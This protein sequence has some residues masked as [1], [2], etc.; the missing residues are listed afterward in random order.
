MLI[1]VVLATVAYIPVLQLPFIDDDYGEIPMAAS[2]YSTGW[3]PLWQDANLRAR[4]TN[5]VLN[6]ALDRVFGFTPLPFYV[7][8]IVVHT[9]CVLLVYA[10]GVWSGVLN[11]RATFWAACFFAIFEGHQEA[12]MWISARN[13]SLLFLFGMA[14]WVCWVKYLRGGRALWYGLAV[15]SLIL[16]AV[17]KESFV[18][19][20]VLML[21][22]CIWPPPG[23]SRRRALAAVIPFFAIVA[24]YLSWS[25]VGRTAQPRFGD[26]RFSILAPWPL[27]ILKSWWRMMWMWGVA[28]LAIV[29]WIGGPGDRRKA[30]IAVVWMLLA[31]FPYSF[32]TYMPQIASRHTY[33]ASAGL[34]LLIGVAAARLWETNRRIVLGV[35]AAAVLVINVEIIWVK[36]M[37]Q[38]RERAEPA[39]L[40][41]E[42]AREAVGPIAIH[43]IPFENVLTDDVLATGGSRAV[44]P[45]PVRYEDHC[46]EIEYQNAAGAR[47]RID[48]RVR[49]GKH[50]A[51][52]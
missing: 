41:G 3:A 13:E 35:A 17:S 10:F 20:P 50:G 34:A 29:A 25:W 44:Y 39:V 26:S 33:I 27:V 15:V 23:T 52:Y 43:C 31:I 38:F 14:A 1:L 51:F 6:G 12:V 47:V 28:A 49:T 37:A 32:L 4:T 9:I 19:F 36:K 21:L 7:V 5:M 40:L 45:Q 48:R 24:V 30:W 11:E 46:F 18:I 42:A 22:P 16:A 8:S 2:F